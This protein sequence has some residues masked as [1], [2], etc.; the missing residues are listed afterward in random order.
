MDRNKQL[1]YCKKCTKRKFDLKQGLICNLT[2]QKADF[3]NECEHFEIDKIKISA[4][5][6]KQKAVRKSKISF[7]FSPKQIDNLPVTDLNKK[8]LYVLAFETAK[9]LNWNIGFLSESGFIAYTKM[10]LFSW[11]EEIQ[12]KI[13]VGNINI[14]SECTGSQIVDWGKNR[15]NIDLFLASFQKSRENIANLNI[16]EQYSE[17]SKKFLD[18]EEDIIKPP[19]NKKEKVFDIISL[20]TPTKGFVVTPIIVVLNILVFTIMAINGVNLLMPSNESL[21]LW[22]ANFRPLT[23][24]GEW[25]RLFTSIFLHIGILHLFM[26]MYALLYIGML[27]EPYLGTGR[28]LFAYLITGISGSIASI[29]W[30]DL[31]ISAGASGAIF[32]MYGVFLALL[33]TRFI[34]ESAR[35]SLLISIGI[36]VLYNLANG[37][38]GGIDNAA[39]IGGLLSGLIIGYAYYPGL[40]KPDKLLKPLTI[41]ILVLVFSIGSFAI[42]KNIKSDVADYFNDMQSFE[43]MEQKA[44]GLYRL[45]PT[46]TDQ[47]FILEVDNGIKYWEECLKIIEKADTYDLPDDLHLRNAQIKEYCHLRIRSYQTMRKAFIEHTNKYDN[48]IFDLN[49]EIEKIIN[50]LRKTK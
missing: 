17:L 36:F 37:L 16:E 33:T 46:S 24:Q 47:Q 7:G 43:Q 30:N 19:L 45:P 26:N 44:L 27:L 25:W 39:H 40:K 22:G 21:L 8:Q 28:F 48:E 32:G 13:E 5:I 41:G 2:N 6:E 11:G 31:I 15:K 18:A 34:E 29:Y 23:I 9:K 20:I 10:S 38:K 50:A 14:K 4:E 12:I 35:K 49:K 1:E 42:V 3:E